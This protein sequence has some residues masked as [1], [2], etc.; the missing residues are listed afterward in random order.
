MGD[1][2]VG[3][4]PMMALEDMLGTFLS[5]LEFYY[6]KLFLLCYVTPTNKPRANRSPED[7]VGLVIVPPGLVC[8]HWKICSEFFSPNWKFI[9]NHCSSYVM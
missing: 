8:W 7:P 9:T 2:L 5:K 3:T 6:T 4:T 1:G